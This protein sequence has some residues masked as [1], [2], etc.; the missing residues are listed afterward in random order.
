MANLDDIREKYSKWEGCGY[1]SNADFLQ[2]GNDIGELLTKIDADAK[3]IVE[4]E[5]FLQQYKDALGDEEDDN[6]LLEKRIADAREIMKWHRRYWEIKYEGINDEPDQ[7]SFY[8]KEVLL[9]IEEF[10]AWLKA[11]KNDE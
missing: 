2:A 1:H 5:K 10:D 3:E 8:A 9:H 6:E 7:E 11:G 4:Y